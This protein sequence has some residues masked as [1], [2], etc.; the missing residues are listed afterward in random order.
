M[1]SLVSIDALKW[2]VTVSVSRLALA[3]LVHFV[4]DDPTKIPAI[5]AMLEPRYHIAPQVLGKR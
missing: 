5:R 1:I 3:M 4:T 2:E